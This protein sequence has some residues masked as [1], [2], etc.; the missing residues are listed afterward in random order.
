MIPSGPVAT[1]TAS[2]M[3]PVVTAV[4]NA[5]ADADTRL[6]MLMGSYLEGG[7]GPTYGVGDNGTS[8]G[9]FQ[10][11]EGGALGSL[12]GSLNQQIAEAENPSTAVAAMLSRYQAAVASVGAALFQSNP[13][14]AGEEAAAIAEAPNAEGGAQDQAY[15]TQGRPVAAAYLAASAALNGAPPPAPGST[16]TSPASPSTGAGASTGGFP[17]S[18]ASGS[19][20]VSGGSSENCMFTVPI[21]LAGSVCVPNPIT[22]ALNSIEELGADV[23]GFVVRV[24]LGMLGCIFLL[25]GLWILSAKADSDATGGSSSGSDKGGGAPKVAEAAEVAAM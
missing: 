18:T 14:Q 21:P 8:F 11:H 7:W 24:G 5:T 16:T 23:G 4:E 22:G 10:M 17:G 25:V 20:P 19:A 6:A 2:T 9:P 13:A 12:P 1:P 3:P 15:Y